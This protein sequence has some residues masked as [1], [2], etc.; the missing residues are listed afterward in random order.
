MEDVCAGYS[1]TLAHHVTRRFAA[2]MIMC[3]AGLRPKSGWE[4]M[5]LPEGGHKVGIVRRLLKERQPAHPPVQD[6]IGK[7]SC[8]EAWAA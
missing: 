7:V 6:V 3:K 2:R 8:R 1:Q 5:S 4:S